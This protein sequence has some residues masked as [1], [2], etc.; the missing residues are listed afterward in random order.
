MM[1]YRI[2]PKTADQ[3]P[4]TWK[5]WTNEPT[6]QNSRPLSTK[7][8]SPSVRSVTGSVS[9][10]SSGRTKVLTRPSN[11]AAMRAAGI[12]STVIE[13]MRNGS[14]SSAAA[15]ISHTNKSRIAINPSS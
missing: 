3:N 4:A 13:D 14:A 15:L 10:I 6:N 8:N 9:R 12:E 7:M 1:L 5:P 2:A 11:K